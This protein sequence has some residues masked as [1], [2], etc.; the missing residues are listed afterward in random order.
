MRGMR[1]VVVAALLSMATLVSIGRAVADPAGALPASSPVVEAGSPPAMSPVVAQG[2]AGV[3]PNFVLV[4]T[5][6]QRWDSIGRCAPTFDGSDYT[7]GASSCMPQVAQ[8]LVANGVTFLRGEVTQSLCCPS[9]ASILTGQYTRHHGVN[10]LDGALLDDSATLA[11]WLDAAGYRTGLVGKYLNGYGAGSLANYIPPGWD[12]FHSFHGYTNQDNPYTDYPWINW[13]SGG[14]MEVTRYNN[15]DSTSTAAC[16]AGNLYSTDLICKQSKD[17]LSADTT[18]PFFLYVNPASP[19]N[20]QVVAARHQ[21][22]Y[23]GLTITTY[24][25]HNV[26]PSPNPPAYLP[27]TPLKANQM[28]RNLNTFRLSL[29]QNRAVDDMVGSLY[30]QLATDGRLANTVWIFI[31]DNGGGTGEH[32]LTGKQCPYLECHRVPFIMVCP[33]GI[34]PGAASGTR[35]ATNYA[36]NIDIAPTI[37]ALAGATATIR[38]DGRSL[39]PILSNPTTPWRTEWGLYDLDAPID[40]IVAKASTGQWYKYLVGRD[41][42]HVQLYNLTTDPW[43]LTNLWNNAAYTAIQNDMAAKLAN[44]LSNP[45]LTITQQP[46]ATGPGTSATFAYNSNET[47]T[48]ECSLDGGA[49][50]ACGTGTTGTITYTGLTAATHTVKIQAVDA[51]GNASPVSTI[52][53]TLTGGGGGDTEPPTAPA[54]LAATSVT[55]AAVSL[56][57]GASTDDV[58]VTHYAVARNGVDIATATGTSY[59]DTTVSPSTTYS[60]VVRAVDAAGNRSPASNEISVTT[61]ATPPSDTVPP[62][63]SITAPVSGATV[64]GT[65][66]VS[67]TATDNVAVASVQV[68]VDGTTV[69]T[70][71]TAPYSHAWNTTTVT[72]GSHTLTAV[73]TDTAGN[74]ATSTA[75]TVTVSNTVPTGQFTAAPNPATTG[76]VITFTDTHP[77]NHRRTITYGDGTQASAR[78]KT[79]TKT[80]T[81]A[82]TYTATLETISVTT[83]LRV[84]LTLTITITTGVT[85]TNQLR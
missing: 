59:T 4:V 23:T 18:T 50:T 61:P 72:N 9:R 10:T 35:D 30:D 32:R 73:A 63:V 46:P 71:T 13:E 25:S 24:P 36:L 6:D 68:K 29:E 37:V 81:T 57:W 58:G 33:T 26:I 84:T 14:T 54:G 11:T 80:Y 51:Y 64:S 45:T 15:V 62:T 82:G 28:T 69:A 60:Y 83:G 47:V 56:S 65:T 53:F 75:V 85:G 67:M 79:F 31:S 55:H 19:H 7:S 74:T 70:D 5:D 20:P 17:F 2:Q 44:F 41:T 40:G 49:A 66:T 8:K 77:G 52:T 3:K 34:C 76:Q 43:E 22:I 78:S 27:A 38:M 16:A 1:F 12:S 39:L 48:F 21:G 42:G